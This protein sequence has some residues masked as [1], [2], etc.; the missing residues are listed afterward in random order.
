MAIEENKKKSFKEK[1]D[2]FLLKLQKIKLDEKI[3]FTKNLSVMIKAGLSLSHAFE[4]LA[5]QTKNK[6]F[7]LA[8]ESAQAE[9]EAGSSLADSLA[10]YVDIFPEI[11]INMVRAGE[12]SG[13]LERAL[14]ELTTQMKQTREL[15]S[16]L[17]KALTYPVVIVCIM[18]IIGI[19]ALTFVIPQMMGIFDEMSVDLPLPTKILIGLSNFLTGN[20][21][22]VAPVLIIIIF[23]FW[24][25]TRQGQ[26]RMALHS[27]LLKFPI[28]GSLIKKVNLIKFARTFSSLLISGISLVQTFQI[29]ARVLD[30]AVYQE[31]VEQLSKETTKGETISNILS[32]HPDLFPLIV[33]QMIEVGEKT[34]TLE[35][36]LDD[37]IEFYE[38]DVDE[39]LTNFAT[40]IEPFLILILGF[41]VAVMALAIIMPMYSLVEAI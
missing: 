7:Q 1:V 12:S 27:F 13:Q 26:G 34:G 9:I 18:I 14:G 32:K 31:K 39:T 10:K 37:I 29:T 6:K 24:K 33:T 30:N 20:W 5:R 3:L 35:N 4:I 15:N 38:D 22:V 36:I 11:F 28:L 19:F 16:K 8:L 21:Y 17:K 2:I 23:A 25:T 41:G 40:I